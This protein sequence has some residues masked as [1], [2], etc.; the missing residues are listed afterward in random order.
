MDNPTKG[1]TLFPTQLSEAFKE[2][3]QETIITRFIQGY[4]EFLGTAAEN[5]ATPDHYLD[6]VNLLPYILTII[7]TLLLLCQYGDN[8]FDKNV[9]HF[10][11]QWS[12]L[13]ISM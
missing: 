8:P 13:N 6:W 7:D 1:R 9:T 3:G 4:H 5:N 10:K 2:S 11:Q 12:V